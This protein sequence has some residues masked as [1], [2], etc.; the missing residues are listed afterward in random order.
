MQKKSGR[1]VIDIIFEDDVGGRT[2]PQFVKT[3]VVVYRDGA[4]SPQISPGIKRL[5]DVETGKADITML[6]RKEKP[7]RLKIDGESVPDKIIIVSIPPKTS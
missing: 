3:E 5:Y 6:T 1:K 2:D 7:T 4:P